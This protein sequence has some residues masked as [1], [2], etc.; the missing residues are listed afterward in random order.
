M[1]TKNLVEMN[2]TNLKN[3]RKLKVN[4]MFPRTIFSNYN[5]IR[6]TTPRKY[7]EIYK[8]VTN[9][10]GDMALKKVGRT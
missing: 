8:I 9:E 3:K 6:L 5:A 10:Y 1:L 4:S 7:Q 2:N